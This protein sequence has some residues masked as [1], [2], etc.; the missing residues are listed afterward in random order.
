MQ[1]QSRAYLRAPL[2]EACVHPV[3]GAPS[4]TKSRAKGLR[5]PRRLAHAQSR[6]RPGRRTLS[7][8]RVLDRRRIAFANSPAPV[9]A[10]L[11]WRTPGAAGAGGGADGPAGSLQGDVERRARRDA[12]ADGVLQ[13]ENASSKASCSPLRRGKVGT[14]SPQAMANA[15]AVPVE[16]RARSS[17][18]RTSAASRRPGPAADDVGNNYECG[19]HGCRADERSS[20]HRSSRREAAARSDGYAEARQ[21]GADAASVPGDWSMAPDCSAPRLSG[22]V[23]ARGRRRPGRARPAPDAALRRASPR[24]CRPDGARCDEERAANVLTPTARCA[25]PAPRPRRATADRWDASARGGSARRPRPLSGRPYFAA[26]A[27]RQCSSSASPASPR[28]R[29]LEVVARRRGSG[30]DRGD[31]VHGASQLG[32]GTTR[33]VSQER[34]GS[35]IDGL[36]N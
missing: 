9:S 23:H 1:L 27:T 5:R 7:L 18:S 4:F 28:R 20:A 2:G 26:V 14:A 13:S 21:P 22:C 30:D 25:R 24:A 17:C 11:A 33:R 8:R 35:A 16:R 10:P 3:R 29:A 12:G 19:L 36:A 32:R 34:Y 31:G 6:V 15:G